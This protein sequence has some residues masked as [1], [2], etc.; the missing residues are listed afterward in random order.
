MPHPREKR[1]GLSCY[2]ITDIDIP[3][4]EVERIR[5]MLL[6]SATLSATG[7]EYDSG[8]MKTSKKEGADHEI[9]FKAIGGFMKQIYL[10]KDL[11][12]APVIVAWNLHKQVIPYL[13]EQ[14]ARY[15]IKPT[16]C[17]DYKIDLT[18]MAR[19]WLKYTPIPNFQEKTV[20][21]YL[22]IAEKDS[23]LRARDVFSFFELQHKRFLADFSKNKAEQA[24]YKKKEDQ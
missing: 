6:H 20:A 23:L 1:R 12:N 8:Q 4:G 18:Y 5:M 13:D 11:S 15:K 19:D 7:N 24:Y 14:F 10:A 2:L 17:P 21:A 9:T 22:D 16:L 3:D